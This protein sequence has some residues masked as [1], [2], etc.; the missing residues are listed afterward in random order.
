M[1]KT[2]VAVSGYFDPLHVGHLEYLELAKALGD[3]LVVIVNN[4][5]QA[6]MKKGKPFMSL[7]DRMKIVGSLKCV[8]RVIASIDRDGSQCETLRML[9]PDIF[10]KGGDRYAHE[11]PETPVCKEL[12]I[13]IIDG[14]GAK[15]RSSSDF[16][17]QK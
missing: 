13:K 5:A 16:V 2:V 12:G 3:E 14:L 4:D 11:I 8:D 15:I 17:K 9:K 7:P 6:I 10:A 1:K